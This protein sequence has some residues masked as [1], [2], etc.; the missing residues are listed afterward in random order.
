MNRTPP[1]IAILV[2]NTGDRQNLSQTVKK[3]QKG[4]GK[5]IGDHHARSYREGARSERKNAPHKNPIIDLNWRREGKYMSATLNGNKSN[6]IVDRKC[7][8]R[9]N[10]WQGKDNGTDRRSEIR[11]FITACIQSTRHQENLVNIRRARGNTGPLRASRAKRSRS[12]VSGIMETRK[13]ARLAEEMEAERIREQDRKGK[14]VMKEEKPE[15][16][17]EILDISDEDESREQSMNAK[18]WE[19]YAMGVSQRSRRG[20]RVPHRGRQRRNR[21]GGHEAEPNSGQDSEAN[22]ARGGRG[23]RT[24][25]SRRPARRARQTFEQKIQQAERAYSQNTS[26]RIRRI[27]QNME[28]EAIQAQSDSEME[29]WEFLVHDPGNTRG[30]MSLFKQSLHIY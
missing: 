27:I 10:R 30:R 14:G 2:R 3:C 5:E 19:Q 1:R 12:P 24:E 21:Q 17:Y 4:P 23:E 16:I 15:E 29:D 20:R 18:E 7:D 28:E 25:Q 11:E 6:K 9:S 26:P 13:R 22:R 8:D